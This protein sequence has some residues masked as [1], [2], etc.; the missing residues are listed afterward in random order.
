MNPPPFPL[1]LSLSLP[2]L[3]CFFPL[4]SSS[5]SRPLMLLLSSRLALHCSSPSRPL[6][7]PS[8]SFSSF[9]SPFRM[10]TKVLHV[11]NPLV[12]SDDS[13]IREAAS[14][15]KDG[16]VVA[17]PTETVYGLGANALS[18]TAVS[19]I[20]RAKNRPADN[21]LIVHVPD[22]PS[23]SPLL[24]PNYSLPP[25]YTNLLERFWPGPLTILLPKSPTI[26]DLVTAGQPTIAVRC[27]SHPVAQALLR[28]SSLPI[29]APSANLST[30][31]SPTKADH[32]IHDLNGRIPLV[33]SGGS[34]DVGVE[35]TVIDALRHPPLILRPGGISLQDIRKVPGFES[36]VQYGSIESGGPC[37]RM[38][39]AP[40]TPGMKYKH[41]APSASLS[42]LLPSPSLSPEARKSDL[43]HR[44]LLQISSLP[45]SARIGIIWAQEPLSLPSP[46]PLPIHTTTCLGQGDEPARRLFS[47]LRDMDHQNVSHILVEGMLDDDFP[48]APAVMNRLRKA[49]LHILPPP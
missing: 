49:A 25:A 26:P 14:L 18:S 11:S 15:L 7:L 40:S 19:G 9:C 46:P 20:F 13:S 2:S 16:Q 42:L 41:Y 21:P 1:P 47:T 23:L 29:A 5:R 24:P 35:S 4:L 36:T 22:I 3:D 43:L 39:D 34:S 38:E 8:P 17:F 33:L 10:H 48:T 12:P 32:V 27:P 45:S 30:R 31:P 28:A 37:P 44:L 6:I